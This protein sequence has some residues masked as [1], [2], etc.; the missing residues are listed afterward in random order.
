MLLKTLK[1]FCSFFLYSRCTSICLLNKSS[2]SPFLD[3]KSWY[4]SSNTSVNNCN[5]CDSLNLHMAPGNS[6]AESV[7]LNLP[8]KKT[9]SAALPSAGSQVTLLYQLQMQL[10][11]AKINGMKG[12]GHSPDPISSAG[13]PPPPHADTHN[14]AKEDPF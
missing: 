12:D 4:Q 10:S 1:P 11:F 6:V 14:P 5:E 9:S 8:Q 2:L 13:N 3:L 7:L